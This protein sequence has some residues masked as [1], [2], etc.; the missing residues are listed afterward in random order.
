M[1]DTGKNFTTKK[2]CCHAGVWLA[3]IPSVL[4]G[5]IWKVWRGFAG[6]F[7]YYNWYVATPKSLPYAPTTTTGTTALNSLCP[8]NWQLPTNTN[9]TSTGVKSY[10]NL[11]DIYGIGDNA[12]GSIALKSA[13]LYFVR[14]GDYNYSGNMIDLGSGGSYWSSTASNTPYAYYLG[15]GGSGVSPQGNSGRGV[16][17]PLRCVAR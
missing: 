1:V 13:P 5:V 2:N 12:E 11:T 15:F 8:K 4:V 7:H 10:A 14:S 17:F 6:Y 16:G 9:P 3:A